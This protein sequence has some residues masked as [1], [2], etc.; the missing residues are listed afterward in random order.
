MWGC[1]LDLGQHV[2]A[3]KVA[4]R[5]LAHGWTDPTWGC[6]AGDLMWC[7]FRGL[8]AGAC[9]QYQDVQVSP[10]LN[11]AASRLKQTRKV[12]LSKFVF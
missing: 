9:T 2:P 11:E 12:F 10:G 4:E 8:Q 1:R 6:L 5:H 7:G 3:Q